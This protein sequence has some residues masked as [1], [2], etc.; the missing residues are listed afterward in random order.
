MAKVLVPIVVA[1][2]VVLCFG[3]YGVKIDTEQAYKEL[4]S[5]DTEI[6]W[7]IEAIKVLNAEWGHLNRPTYL[8][9]HA[10]DY[11][12]LAQMSASQIA[13]IDEVP[14]LGFTLSDREISSERGLR[15]AVRRKPIGLISFV[16]DPR[17][18]L[19]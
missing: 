4:K 14:Y 10:T 12:D 15:A 18:E 5:L 17:Q 6:T 19:N 9:T 1:A 3:L 16:E 11:L 8:E 7:E 2:F 13:A